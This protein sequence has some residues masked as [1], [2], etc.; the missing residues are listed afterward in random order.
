MSDSEATPA[1]AISAEEVE[2]LREENERLRE[3]VAAAPQRTGHRGKSILSAFI[4][5]VACL[6]APL[7]VVAVWAKG[8]VTDTNRYVETVAPLAE[9]PAIQE[10][11]AN[12]ISDA[13]FAKINL[14]DLTS[15]VITALADNRGL[16]AEQ[17]AALKGLS[18][19]VVSGIESFIRDQITKVIQSPQFAQAWATANEAAHDALVKA[20][21]GQDTGALQVQGNEVTLN[22]APVL[23]EVKQKLV[24]QGFTV[25]EKI[26]SVD[27]NIVLFQSDS[28]SK[29][30][31]FYSL[32]EKVGFWMPI[33]VAILGIIAIFVANK[34]YVAVMGLGIGLILSMGVGLMLMSIARMEYLDKLP[35]TVNPQAAQA[36]FDQLT[37]F[38]KGSLVSGVVAG[39]VLALAGYFVGPTAGGI[40]TR[41]VSVRAAAYVQAR[42]YG[43]G[44]TMTAVRDFVRRTAVMWRV[45]AVII[46][47]LI[48]FTQQYKSGTL[49]IWTAIGLLVALFIIQVLASNAQ[50]EP[51]S[52]DAADP[53]QAS[54]DDGPSGDDTTGETDKVVGATS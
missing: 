18:G 25:A 23:D 38:L 46:A 10:A 11:V 20:L 54:G 14:E 41:R 17:Q 47:L 22:L 6:L 15:N 34:R 50:T 9:N 12:K 52:P 26:P 37:E 36:V 43:W 19:P 44:A 45:I 3:Q 35:S 21:S 32:L 27:T 40:A 29:M 53:D 8:E 28:I 48:I 49:I 42:L 4:I 2:R 13:I 51:D 33:I 16:T 5:I 31:Q 1:P 30:Q 24:A 39:V 7:S